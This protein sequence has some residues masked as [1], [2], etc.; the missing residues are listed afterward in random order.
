[1]IARIQKKYPDAFIICITPWFQKRRTTDTGA[2]YLNSIGKSITDY[3][4]AVREVCGIMHVSCIEG[5]NIGFNRRNYYPTY[6]QDTA[7]QS[8]HPNIAGQ[9]QIAKAV[10]AQMRTLHR[11]GA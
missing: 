2:N 1:M 10:I 3:A 6:C 7:T 11:I 5:T 8:T 9:A 4:D